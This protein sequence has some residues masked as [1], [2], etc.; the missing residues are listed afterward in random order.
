M[1]M[2]ILGTGGIGRVILNLADSFLKKGFV[3]D[4]VFTGREYGGRLSEI[5]NGVNII[6]LSTRSRYSLIPAIRYL[7]KTKPDLIISAHN[8]VNA[9][10][11]IAHRLSGIGKNCFVISTFHTY[12]STQLK[13]STLQGRLYDWLAFRFY[14]WANKLVAVSR[15]V[16][17][18]IEDSAGL[19]KGTINVIYNPA[20]SEEMA[21]KAKE[22]CPDPWVADRSIPLIISAGRLT[23]E[24]DF[25]TLLRA[26][27]RL[28]ESLPAQ[29]MILG[30]G[31]D[32]KDLENL[33]KQLGLTDHVR[34]PGH[35]S[36]PLSY[37]SNADLFVLSSA[38]EGFGNVLVEALGCG[39]PIVSTNCPGGA[40]EILA[41][42]KY[43]KMVPVK[44]DSE[45]GEAMKRTL[46]S[47]P[48]SEHQKERAQQFTF[49][50]S[51]NKYLSLF[52]C[53]T[54]NVSQIN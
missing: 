29:L 38:W 27:A 49:E 20:W 9:L 4:L 52:E 37:F 51:A 36:N 1:S 54:N 6:Q 21:V 35:V 13:N 3:V 53:G 32:R 26:F 19:P 18:D 47:P 12:R 14:G 5:P 8:H 16:A 11:L 44:D 48:S 23:K 42:G 7:K 10:M 30:E 17:N 34:L 2:G 46:E 39:L 33:I 45:L 31:E 22:P 43:G 40:R 50:R 25:P 41:D 28:L 15:G 24:K